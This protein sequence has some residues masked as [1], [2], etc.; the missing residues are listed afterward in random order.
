[1]TLN[2][3]I[4]RT[5]SIRRFRREP[6]KNEDLMEMVELAG[7]SPSAANL[8]PLKYI[9]SSTPHSNRLIFPHTAWA[10][11]LKDW[12]GPSEEEQPA[13][14]I[15]ILQDEEIASN[16]AIDVGIAA[17]TIALAAAAKGIGACMLGSLQRNKICGNLSIPDNL[18]I[19]L[20]IALGYPAEKVVLEET[21]E[22]GSIKYYRDTS[23]I[24]H[25]PKRP[26]NEILLACI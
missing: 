21:K 8:Q 26:L 6:L 1:M 10:G 4:H 9:I 24:H 12:D 19:A 20:V 14:Y 16:S 3:I 7:I 23:D 11:Y 13:A 17:W 2:K 18:K 25:V 5:R 15:I 22:D